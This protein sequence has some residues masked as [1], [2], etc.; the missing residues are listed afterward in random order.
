MKRR[1]VS[2]WCWRGNIQRAPTVLEALAAEAIEARSPVRIAAV[3]VERTSR[4]GSS[5]AGMNRSLLL[6]RVAVEVKPAWM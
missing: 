1:S 6:G 4:T 3:A 2:R 5:E